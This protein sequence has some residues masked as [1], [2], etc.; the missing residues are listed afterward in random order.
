MVK[1]SQ[2]ISFLF[3][4]L[5]CSLVFSLIYPFYTTIHKI[6]LVEGMAATDIS[7]IQQPID[8]YFNTV[9]KGACYTAL[10]KIKSFPNASTIMQTINQQD[11]SNCSIIDN[12]SNLNKPDTNIQKAINDCYGQK[13]SAV[14]TMIDSIR[15]SSTYKNDSKFSSFFDNS[16]KSPSVKGN[17]STPDAIQQY[18]GNMATFNQISDMNNPTTSPSPI[19]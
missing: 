3:V 5:I 14:L 9:E 17:N 6:P 12:I 2:R 11:I 19:K 10:S 1:Q 4:I 18:I 8:T 15:S 16:A 7:N 13:Y